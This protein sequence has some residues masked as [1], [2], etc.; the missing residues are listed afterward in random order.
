MNETVERLAP[1]DGDRY[2]PV[3]ERD[4]DGEICYESAL[5]LAGSFKISSVPELE[6]ALKNKDANEA[7]THCRACPHSNME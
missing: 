5:C 6:D 1:W 7:R 2:C 4:I 3:F